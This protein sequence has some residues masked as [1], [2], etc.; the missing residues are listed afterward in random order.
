M[1]KGE[2]KS[3]C[4]FV[5]EKKLQNAPSGT[6]TYAI[7]ISNEDEELIPLKIYNV[8]LHQHLQT[9]TVKDENNETLVCPINWFLPIEFPENIEKVIEKAE[10]ALT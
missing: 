2:L 7:C 3:N 8:V 4:E 1:E 5:V 9:C 10:L 6:K